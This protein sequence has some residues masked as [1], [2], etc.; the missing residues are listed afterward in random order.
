MDWK[1][2]LV[3]QAEEIGFLCTVQ[4]ASVQYWSFWKLQ[5]LPKLLALTSS[6]D[7]KHKAHFTIKFPSFEDCDFND[8]SLPEPGR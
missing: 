4:D 5:V 1:L 3:R 8:L 2:F 7:L 6:R